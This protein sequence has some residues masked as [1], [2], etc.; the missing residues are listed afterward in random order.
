VWFHEPIF[1]VNE[2]GPASGLQGAIV[3]AIAAMAIST[4]TIPSAAL[5]LRF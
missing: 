4:T 1:T 5:K 2:L 3:A